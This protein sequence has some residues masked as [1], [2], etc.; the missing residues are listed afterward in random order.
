MEYKLETEARRTYVYKN[1]KI[2]TFLNVSKIISESNSETIVFGV[3]KEEESVSDD[4]YYIQCLKNNKEYK[5]FI[6]EHS[7]NL[8]HLIQIKENECKFYFSD[9]SYTIYNVRYKGETKKHIV[10]F[11][12]SSAYFINKSKLTTNNCYINP[13]IFKNKNYF[14]KNI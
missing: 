4:F 2:I 3:K 12:N 1:E 5:S 14:S 13:V 10:I 6:K 7:L 11:T 9:T 8:N